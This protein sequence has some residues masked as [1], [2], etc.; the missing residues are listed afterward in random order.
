MLKIIKIITILLLFTELA[1]SAIDQKNSP[2]HFGQ[3]YLYNDFSANK[4]IC[5]IYSIPKKSDGNYR[6]REKAYF[7]IK[8]I[9]NDNVEITVS[10]GFMHKNSSEV[11]IS[12]KNKKFN[13]FTFEN[14]AW[15]YNKSQ[16]IDIIKEMK[17]S[18][19]LEIYAIDIYNKYAKDYYSLDGFLEA[20]HE[21]K[22]NCN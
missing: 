10:S 6:K 19:D 4:K 17:K 3:W 18:T 16:D 8:N 7:L 11:E 20:Y 9:K 1:F 22:K 14:L 5:Y 15:A 2:K 21:M 13:I 12:L